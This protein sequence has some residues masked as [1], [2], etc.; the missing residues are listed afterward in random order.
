[1]LLDSV[2]GRRCV[3]NPIVQITHHEYPQGGFLLRGERSL[4]DLG[5]VRLDPAF[6]IPDLLIERAEAMLERL[7]TTAANWAG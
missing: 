7:L 4:E 1:M 2:P 6:P 5:S 3:P